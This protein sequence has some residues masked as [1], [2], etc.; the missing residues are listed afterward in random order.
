MPLRV[1]P[2]CPRIALAA[3]FALA[4]L[5]RPAAGQGF[6]LNARFKSPA[7]H[8]VFQRDADDLGEVPVVLPDDVKG[9]EIL[10]VTVQH[11]I[12]EARGE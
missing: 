1:S 11:R 8:Q 5:A 3:A 4:C 9:A 10:G 2:M 12:E 7:P 6:G